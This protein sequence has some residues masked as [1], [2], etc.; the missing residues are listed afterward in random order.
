MLKSIE[1]FKEEKKA[2]ILRVDY[3]IET[4][5]GKV[6]DSTRI[7]ASLK[8][9]KYLLKLNSRIILV[10]HRGRPEGKPDKELSLE[11]AAHALAE[12]LDRKLAVVDERFKLP[13]YPMPHLFFVKGDLRE[14][15]LKKLK[16]LMADGDIIMLEN[17][18]FYK[19]EDE[20]NEKFA[21][22]LASLGDV[23]VNEAFSVN[24]HASTSVSV[25]PKFLPH[26][27]GFRLQEELEVLG[28]L[29]HSVK[30]PLVL[31]VGGAKITD[32]QKMLEK[33]LPKADVLLAGGA[34]ASLFLKIK[35]YS[36]GDSV[37]QK[38][39][40]HTARD[41]IRNYKEKIIIPKDV[42]VGRNLESRGTVRKINE[43]KPGE[44]IFDIGPATILEYSKFIKGAATIIWNGPMGVCEYKSF[45]HG[46]YALARLI[47]SRAKRKTFVVAGGGETI[48]ALDQTT[49]KDNIDFISTG[50]GSMLDLLGGEKLP[51]VEALH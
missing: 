20:L 7:E 44:K 2:V 6:L 49:L 36:I 43:I 45:S 46:T 15:D 32:K 9:I 1:K 26:Y 42:V 40:V 41:I 24:H 12:Y 50:G 30:K 21:K 11:P 8:T 39:G 22:L 10:S 51:G 23:Y 17:I 38:E 37:I 48:Q 31:V 34:L 29:L 14:M 19:Q 33:L 18:R 16:H 27:A 47:A 25:L 28:R 3:N 13:D 35:N 4:K 5:N